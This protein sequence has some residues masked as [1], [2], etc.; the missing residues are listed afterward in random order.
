MTAPQLRTEV[1][2]LLIDKVKEV[3]E[4]SGLIIDTKASAAL[5]EL[6]SKINHINPNAELNAEFTAE[7]QQYVLDQVEILN[8]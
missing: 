6:Y 3:R 2:C 4:K 7:R 1:L 5:I 8:K